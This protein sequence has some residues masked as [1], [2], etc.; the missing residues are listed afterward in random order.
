[1]AD[2]NFPLTADEDLDD[3]PRTLRRE[4]AER[5]REARG[6]DAGRAPPA[7]DLGAPIDPQYAEPAYEDEPYAS[8]V[9]RFD[10]PFLHL[11]GFFIKAVLAGIPALILLGAIIYGVGEILQAFFPWIVKMK[12]VILFPEV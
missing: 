11:M 9:R 2:Q 1:M 4:R 7:P 12:I 10:V 6:R 5:E 3:L 8:T